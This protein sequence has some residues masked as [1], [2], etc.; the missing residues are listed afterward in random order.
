MRRSYFLCAAVVTLLASL[1]SSP[2]LCDAQVAATPA[3]TAPSDRAENIYT[4]PDPVAKF[5]V[6]AAAVLAT[7]CATVFRAAVTRLVF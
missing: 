3:T 2:Q 1:L 5:P 7:D 6:E 4:R